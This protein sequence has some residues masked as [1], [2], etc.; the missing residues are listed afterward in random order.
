MKSLQ[1]VNISFSDSK[2]NIYAPTIYAHYFN[3][4]TFLTIGS[5]SPW[6]LT[7]FAIWI[8]GSASGVGNFPFAAEHSISNEKIRNGAILESTVIGTAWTSLKSSISN[9]IWQVETFVSSVLNLYLFCGIFIH[10][11]P[12]MSLS[13]INLKAKGKLDS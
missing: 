10:Y 1:A 5:T 3:V 6:T 9:S 7:I 4:K 11:I 12:T 8:I 13:I 2:L